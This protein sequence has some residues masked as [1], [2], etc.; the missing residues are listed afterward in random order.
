MLLILQKL[1]AQNLN[2]PSLIKSDKHS[3]LRSK[4]VFSSLRLIMLIRPLIFCWVWLIFLRSFHFPCLTPQTERLT[5]QS[6][7][8]H[9]VRS[10]LQQ[11]VS[12]IQQTA[13]ISKIK[14]ARD[15]TAHICL[16]HST[17]R[18]FVSPSPVTL[19]VC[20]HYAV[21]HYCL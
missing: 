1:S 16:S 13:T 4:R 8:F 21:S 10:E 18:F 20:S 14:C 3:L 5:P 11:P 7:V 12:G 15:V 2:I 6:Q 19:P 17:V 9:T